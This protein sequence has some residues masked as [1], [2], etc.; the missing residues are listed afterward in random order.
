MK[1]FMI[2]GDFL[3][4]NKYFGKFEVCK[5]SIGTHLGGVCFFT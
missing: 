4:L 2:F 5:I 3:K 1:E